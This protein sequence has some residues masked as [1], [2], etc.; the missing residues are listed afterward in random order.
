VWFGKKRRK[1]Q[2]KKVNLKGRDRIFWSRK[3]WGKRVKEKESKRRKKAGCW[4][5]MDREVRDHG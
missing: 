5:P 2:A 4:H 3:A 1:T